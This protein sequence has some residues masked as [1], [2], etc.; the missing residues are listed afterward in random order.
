M[1]QGNGGVARFEVI[2][3][4]PKLTSL[5]GQTPA[6]GLTRAKSVKTKTG[7]ALCSIHRS[8]WRMGVVRHYDDNASRTEF[9]FL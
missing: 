2:L 9:L 5:T 4:K 7:W 8:G 1:L 3:Q 6:S